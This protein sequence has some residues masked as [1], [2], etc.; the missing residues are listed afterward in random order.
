MEASIFNSTKKVLGLDEGYDAFDLNVLTFINSS[1]A[2][3]DQLGV[4]PVG[5]LVIDGPDSVWDDLSVPDNQLGL[6][7]TYIFL[8][9]RMLFDPPTTSFAISAFNEQIKEYE[10]RLNTF[11]ETEPTP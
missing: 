1:L 7:K 9:V 5:G 3:L 6:V 4:G 10:W 11:R 2:T 8:K